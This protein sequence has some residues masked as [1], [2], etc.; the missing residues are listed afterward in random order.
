M[1]IEGS[2]ARKA[3]L[4]QCRLALA[5]DG[6]GAIVLGCGGMAD[7]S[8]EISRELGVPVVDGVAAA[9]KFVEALL[10]LG[11]CTSKVGDLAAPIPKPYTG[12]L[13]PFAPQ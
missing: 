13:A 12:M 4:E 9:V 10:C 6:C 7:L 2:P 3:I 8:T 11:L 1:E 5:E